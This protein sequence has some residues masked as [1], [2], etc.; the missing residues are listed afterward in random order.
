MIQVV[1]PLSGAPSYYIDTIIPPDSFPNSYLAVNPSG[2]VS[3]AVPGISI[4]PSQNAYQIIVR[5][6][7]GTMTNF[8]VFNLIRSEQNEFSPIL[9]HSAN[10]TTTIP[11][12]RPL[13][14]LVVDVNA[15]D[16]DLGQYGNITYEFVNG[17]TNNVFS[18]NSNTGEI[19]IGKLLNYDTKNE[20][21]LRIQA[22]NPVDVAALVVQ[23]VIAN[24]TV[25][26][27]AVPQFNSTLYSINVPETGTS[28][29]GVTYDRPPAGFI[30]VRCTDADTNM[31]EITYSLSGANSDVFSINSTTGQLKVLA[32]LDYDNEDSQ[33]YEFHAICSDDTTS[34]STLVQIAVQPVNEYSPVVNLRK[35]G[36]TGNQLLIIQLFETDLPINQVVVSAT[37][38][39]S[40]VILSASDRDLG[41]D[42]QLSFELQPPI[43]ENGVPLLSINENTGEVI[44]INELD[45]DSE[46]FFITYSF[47]VGARDQPG[48]YSPSK[49]QIL[50]LIQEAA[51]ELPE[52]SLPTYLVFKSEALPINA[53]VVIANC[54]DHDNTKGEFSH[55]DFDNETDTIDNLFQLDNQ[56]GQIT[57]IGSLDYE[58]FQT[59]SFELICY[60]TV[61]YFDTAEVIV[62]VLPV[63]DKIPYFSNSTYTFEVSRTTPAN[64]FYIGAVMAFDDDIGYGANLTYSMESSFFLI[65]PGNGR[66][67]LQ[68][69]I[70]NAAGDILEFNVTVTDDDE[71]HSATALVIFILTAGNYEIPQ[72]TTNNPI[73][74]ISELT[75]ANT[76][77]L[78]LHCNDSEAG[79]NGRISYEIYGGNVGSVFTIDKNSGV[80]SIVTPIIL[81]QNTSSAN[82]LLNVR[83]SDHG[84]PRHSD[85]TVARIIVVYADTISPDISN[86]TI[87]A[88]VDEDA[89]LSDHV[90]TIT[91]VDYDT[92]QLSFFFKSESVPGA[93]LI[94]TQGGKTGEVIVNSILNRETISFYEMIVVAQEV[95]NN[96]VPKNDSADLF[97]Y[98]RDVNDN[99]PVCNVQAL[100]L[101]IPENINV[102]DVIYT[103]NCN[104]SDVGLNANLTYSL[105]NNYGIIGINSQGDIFLTNH[106][107]MTNSSTLNLV[108][109]V[110]DQ[111]F[112]P[113]SISLTIIV[114]IQTMNNFPPTFTN[115]PTSL[116]I[117]EATA[118]FQLPIF[119][120]QAE[121]ADRGQYGI[122]RYSLVGQDTLPF[123]LVPNTG[124]LY[125]QEK[126][127]HH[128]QN[129]YTLNIS[130]S[131]S[132][133]TV[134]STLIINVLDANEYTPT[135]PSTLFTRSI[136]ENIVPSG[137]EPISLGCSDDDKGS[138]GDITY[139]ILSG[140]TNNDFT[141]SST[142]LIQANNKLNY[143]TTDTY[144]LKI[145][146][147]DLGNPAR[148]IIVTV[149][150]TVSP[151]NE[152]TPQ[153]HN[154]PYTESIYED[155]DIGY[156]VF[157][158]NATDMDSG[159]D[160]SLEY[161]LEPDQTAFGVTSQGDV[162]VTGILDRE[163]TSNYS[164]TV[165]VSDMGT[166][167][168]S[169]FASVYIDILD[170]DD[171][172]PEFTKSLYITTVSAD[173]AKL[174]SIVATTKCIDLDVGSNA[175]ISYS[176][177]PSTD[178]SYFSISD[179]GVITI[180]NTLPIS[181]VYSFGVQCSGVLNPNL[182]DTAHVSITI[183]IQSNITFENAT[184][185]YTL[186]EDIVPIY[187]FLTI[188]ATTVT[189]TLLTYSLINSPSIFQINGSSGDLRLVGYLDFETNS[190]YI[191]IVEA[192]DSGTP[193]NTAQVA[194]NILV[195]NINDGV[196]NF[197][198]ATS[199]IVIIEA[200]QYDLPVG[201]YVCTDSDAGTF[202][203]IT[204]SIISGN[205][206]LSF[207]INED[208]GQL[209]LKKKLDYEQTQSLNLQVQCADGGLPAQTDSVIVSVI[210]QPVNEHAPQFSSAVISLTIDE[211]L[212]IP[213]LITS[214][215]DL[216]ATDADLSPHNQIWYSIISGNDN[217]VF[218]ISSTNG[219][220]TLIKNLNFE[221]ISSYILT[222][223]ADDSGGVDNPSYTVLNSTVQVDITVTDANDNSPM[224]D[225]NIYVGSIA[226]NA[227][228]GD[229]VDLIALNCTDRDSGSN[230]QTVLSITQG[231]DGYAFI[232]LSNGKFSV[233]NTLDFESLS[234][235]YLT[236]RCSD[237]G[238]TPNFDEVS[239]IINI[240][241]VSEFGPEFEFPY[242]QFSVN[243]T[244]I[245][246]MIVGRVVAIDQDTGSAGQITYSIN[247]TTEIPFVIDSNTG[248]IRVSSSLDYEAGT[249]TYNINVIAYDFVNQ[250][251]E[252]V[253]AITLLNVDEHVPTLTASNYFGRIRESSS[254]G[255]LVLF[256][257]PISCSDADDV[258]DDL[259]TTFS[260]LSSSDAPL[261]DDFPFNLHQTTGVMT[262][263]SI[264]DLETE[265]RY[266]FK[267]VCTDSAGNTATAVITI[268]L[269]P[270][271]DFAP[272]FEGTPYNK[273]ITEGLSENTEIFT[274][275]ATDDDLSSYNSITYGI[276]SGNEEGRFS[277]DPLS[278]TIRNIQDIDYEQETQYILNISATNVIP[279]SD[280]SGSPELSSYI[281]LVINIT[282][283]NDN[284]PVITPPAVSALIRVEDPPGTFVATMTCDDADSDNFGE[285]SMS[286]TGPNS[287]KFELLANGTIITV[288]IISFDL[289]LLVNCTDMGP[290]PL[291]TLAQITVSSS[292][293]N[294]H[295]PVFPSNLKNFY[296]YE[297]F[298]VGES[299]GCFPANDSDGTLTPDGIITYTFTLLS[300]PNHFSVSQTT[301]C[302][303]LVAALDYDDDS[304]YTYKLRAQDG[305]I[306]Q[307]YADA[308]VVISILNVEFDPP[309]FVSEVFSREMSEG[310][311][312]GAIVTQNAVCTDRDDD[313]IITYSIVGGNDDGIFAINSTTGL[314]TLA[315]SLDYESAIL[316]SIEVRCTD[317]TSLYDEVNVTITV[318]PVNEH[319]PLIISKLV[320]ANEQSSVGTPITIIDYTDLDAGMDGQVTFQIL[321][322]SYS[323][324]FVIAGHTLLFNE[325]LDREIQ[326]R[327]DISMRVTDLAPISRFSD[328]YVNV[329]LTDINDNPPV[330]GQNVYMASPI[331]ENAT[332]GDHVLTVQCNDSDIGVNAQVE[333][334]I[335]ENSLFDVHINNGKVTVK[336]DLRY[337]DQDTIALN[338]YCSDKGTPKLTTS[339][340][341]QIPIHS[342]N[343]H[344][345]V[346]I[347]EPFTVTI[348]ENSTTLVPFANVTA[349]D[350]DVGLN[351]RVQYNLLDDFDNQF[352]IDQVTGEISLLLPLD[353]ETVS[354]YLL[355][356]QA[357]DGSEDSLHMNRKTDVLNVTV[358]VTGINEHTPVCTQPI[359]TGIINRTDQG[360]VLRLNCTDSDRGIDGALSYSIFNSYYSPLFSV[361]PNGE[362]VIKSSI[363]GNSSVEVYVITVIVSDMGQPMKQ[364]EV[365]VNLIYSFIN[366]DEP[367][368]NQT[369]YTFSL[370]EATPIGEVVYTI[371]A[372][373]EDPGIQGDILYSIQGTDYFRVNPNNGELYISKE[374]DWETNSIVTFMLVATDGDPYDPLSNSASVNVTVLDEND[375][376]PHCTLP[377]YTVIIGSSL[378]IGE[379]V[380][381]IGELCYDNDGPLHSI[382]SYKVQPASTFVIDSLGRISVNS[383]LT[384]STTTALTVTVNDNG[385]PQLS[386]TVTVTIQV[387]FDNIASPIFSLSQ[388]S[389]NISEDANLLTVIG[390]VQATD[391]D[392][393]T[394]DLTYS[395]TSVDLA[396]VFY[397]DPTFGDIVLISPLNYENRVQYV[398]TIKVDDAGGYNG[399]NILSDTVSVTISVLNV[400]DHSPVLNNGGL[401]GASVN[402]TTAI[403]TTIITVKC[404]DDDAVPFGNPTITQNGF[405][406]SFPFNLLSSGGNGSITVAEDLTILNGS[407]TYVVNFTCEDQGGQ[408]TIGQVYLFVPDLGAPIFNATS[409]EWQ[410]REDAE[411]GEMFTSIQA[412]SQDGTAISYSITDGNS[413]G[414]F[415]I[416]PDTGVISLA[417][418]LDY[419]TQ[420]S[421]GLIL[422]ATDGHNRVSSVLL[423]VN[424]LDV[425]DHS[426]LVSPSAFMEVE[427]F[428]PP[429]YPVG[430][431]HCTDEDS[432]NTTFN[433]EFT[434]SIDTFR[435]DSNGIIYVNET[436]DTTPVYVLPVICYDVTVPDI[437]STGIVTI[438]VIFVNLA[439]PQFD[440]NSYEVSIPES[441]ETQSS[442]A[443][444]HA[445]DSDIGSLG[446]VTYS[447]TAGNPNKFYIDSQSGV[448][449]L[450]TSLDREDS[451]IYTLTVKAV[452][453]GVGLNNTV[454]KTATTTVT[455]HILDVNDNFP[456]L[457]Q[458]SYVKT[459][460]TN[461]TYLSSVLQV[462]CSDPDLAENGTFT[463][464]IE[465][466]HNSFIINSNGTILLSSIQSSQMVHNFFVVCEDMGSIPLSSSSLVTVVVSKASFASPV[467]DENAYIVS[468]P[469]NQ[470][471][472]EPFLT[473]SA[474]TSDN[475][476]VVYLI[477]AG[478]DGNK[479]YINAESG[480]LTVVDTLSYNQKNLYTLTIRASTTGFVQYSSLV[481][482]NIT[483]TDINDHIPY[484][485]P[486][487]FYTT[488]VSE[489]E[490]ILTP[491]VQVNCS[492]LD[493]TDSLIYS[494]ID[495]TPESGLNT[496]NITTEGLIVIQ[497]P[498][499]YE[500][501]TLFSLTVQCSDGGPT[502]AEAT[503]RVNV[504]PV[505]EFSPLF[506]LPK[507]IFNA[508][509]NE[510]LG[511]VLGNVTA[512]DDDAG[513]H[514]ELIYL[515]QDPGNLSAVFIEPASGAVLVSNI[516]DYETKNFYNLSVIARDYGGR[517]SYV[518]VEITVL[519]VQDVPPVLTPSASVYNGR[520]LTTSPQGLFIKSYICVDEDGGD[521]TISIISGNDM[522]YFVLN[523]FNHVVWDGIS[524]SLNSDIVVSLTLECVDESNAK[525]TA[526]LAI[527]IGRPDT[528][529]PVFTMSTYSSTIKENATTGTPVLSVLAS[530]NGNNTI[531]YSLFNLPIGFPF[532]I[533][534]ATGE[535][536]VNGTLDFEDTQLYSFP[537]QARDINDSTIALATV[538]I[539]VIDIN[540]NY[541]LL[542]PPSLSV[543]LPENSV[544][545]IPYAK[546]TCTDQDDN[547]NSAI[548][549]S[550]ESGDSTM[551]FSISETTG[552]VYLQTSLN[553]ESV[554]SYNITV[555]CTD[556]G[557][558]QLSDSSTLLVQVS[559]INEHYPQFTMESYSFATSEKAALSSVVGSVNATD[560]DHGSNGNFYFA[561]YGGS[562]S[563]YFLVDFATGNISVKNKLNASQA[564]RLTLIVAAIDYGPPTPLISTV[565]V[566]I[567]IEDVNEN[568]YFD[569]LAYVVS[570]EANSIGDTLTTITCYDYDLGLN[571]QVSL[572]VVTNPLTGNVSLTGGSTIGNGSISK[573]LIQNTSLTTGSYEIIVQCQDYGIPFLATNVSVTIIVQAANTPPVFNKQVYGLSVNENV[574]TGTALL[575]ISATDAETGVTY[576][577]TGGT[578]LGTFSIHPNT[579]EL[580]LLASLDYESTFS[581]LLT[582]SAIDG[583]VLNPQT[584]TAKIS[585]VV[586]N[587]NDRNPTLS[588]SAF[589]TTLLE[590]F[591][592]NENIH[593][594]TCTDVDGGTTD[595]TISPSP[596]FVIDNNGQVVFN[597]TADYEMNTVVTG[598]IVC[599]DSVIAAGDSIRSS[600]ATLS[601]SITPV[602]FFPP[603][604]TSPS[605]FNVSEGT[606]TAQVIATVSAYDPDVR[607]TVT[608]STES[609][610]DMFT[611]NSANGQL[612]LLST[613][614]RETTDAYELTITASDNDNVQ[615]VSP[616]T[617]TVSIIINVTDIN[618]RSPT[619]DSTLETITIYANTY[620]QSVSLFN[621]SCRDLDIGLNGELV[622]T[623]DESS[624]P[625]EAFFYLDEKTG[626]FSFNGTITKSSSGSVIGI[627]VSDLGT[628]PV[629]T[630]AQIQL[631]L[632]VITGT[633]PRFEPNNF[634]VTI[635][636]SSPSLFLVLN[637]SVL[638][639]SL[640]FAED[641]E[642]SFKFI[643]N[644]TQFLIDSGTGNVFVLPT[645]M[646]DYDEGQQ[647]YSLGITATVGTEETEASLDIY[648]SDY[649][650][651]APQFT[652]QLYNGTV[653][654]NLDPGQSVLTVFATDIDS[655]SNA[656]VMYSILL[657]GSSFQINPVSGLI[658]SNTQFD[659]ET[660]S[661]YTF[662]V[663]ARDMGN[664]AMSSSV[665]VSIEIGDENDN[666]PE[667][668]QE[669]YSFFISDISKAG[670]VLHT[671][672]AIDPD[673]TGS[674]SYS[675]V[676]QNTF[677]K[678]FLAINP[679][680]GALYLKKDVPPN[681]EL[682]YSFK[683]TANDEIAT[684]ET[685]VVIQIATLRNKS[686]SMEENVANQSF[687]VFQFLQLS[688][689]LTSNTVYTIIDGDEFGH[690]AVMNNGLLINVIPLDRENISFYQLEISA[691]DN[692][693]NTNSILF[694]DIDV[695]DQNDNNPIFNSSLYWFNITEKHYSEN[696]IIGYVFA[697]DADKKNTENSRITYSL[698]NYHSALQVTLN[699]VTGAVSVS[700]T[701]DR[702]TEEITVLDIQ[703]QDH[704][705]PSP[706]YDYTVCRIYIYDVND[707][708]PRFS[709]TNVASFIVYFIYNVPLG[710]Y[711]EYIV[712]LRPFGTP[713]ILQAFE[714]FDEDSSDTVLAS[715][716]GAVNVTL[717]NSTSPAY[718]ISTGDITYNLNNTEFEIILSDGDKAH[719]VKKS[720]LVMILEPQP[721]V[722][723]V[724]STIFPSSTYITLSESMTATPTDTG[725]TFID[726][727]LGIAII[728]VGSVMFFAF[729]FFIFC[730]VCFCY[731]NYQRKKDTARRLV[732]G[733]ILMYFDVLFKASYKCFQTCRSRN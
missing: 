564:E 364:T 403:G 618:D 381:N 132:G 284:N 589:S 610:T 536:T 354:V 295:T 9:T 430:T 504:G 605:S 733:Y 191:L 614:D 205:T 181:S 10:L 198:S 585:I 625:N 704:G 633:E 505:N 280:S 374:L 233:N 576:A 257:S 172:P 599:T 577:L 21:Q 19:T 529:A 616:M 641:A 8:T 346:F 109:T 547:I 283:I 608:Y 508:T 387:T 213:T 463:Y 211:S 14:S 349:T 690:F 542:L 723:S 642:I 200:L 682:V 538:E 705:E 245:P 533:D 497:Q 694:I 581:Y 310:T 421:Y 437:I 358:Q 397:I 523:E 480:D 271:N 146:V 488:T 86:D 175:A 477:T 97:I 291:Y 639:N 638:I 180:N 162:L 230:G 123:L 18:I 237:Q 84:I 619:C 329:T 98:L 226:E 438:E 77:V 314:I 47:R 654:E 44:V 104:D 659:R 468:I 530:G 13:H 484:F 16:S 262:S 225:Q 190:S 396:S 526:S 500:T 675:L 481:T 493:P 238:S 630:P 600:T 431:I 696:T 586:V 427:Q 258:A 561:D 411:S 254:P 108:I 512:T 221:T 570:T 601:I 632:V 242:Y 539:T 313:D 492:D 260:L 710:S 653:M 516:L 721:S 48:T 729:V 664:P 432:S 479:F 506:L 667:F 399:T 183:E 563:P 562:G 715:L 224:F 58:T 12:N 23:Y 319:T 147:S 555:V 59:I 193:P 611:L 624:L 83:C 402:K 359:Y 42:G 658:T 370:S 663:E 447:I 89:L 103:L 545:G 449:N 607:G 192:T 5:C 342:I 464:S 691:V 669:L 323:S 330:P 106:L 74:S 686:I 718:L 201:S 351:G 270:Y 343:Q 681:Y 703:A 719:Q 670:E 711:P 627:S 277:I 145:Q 489:S 232:I 645:A 461:H 321:D 119:T 382:L 700:G 286:L 134:Y 324:L 296:V 189:G 2:N 143:E 661:S 643:A 112:T 158:V 24:V 544:T 612:I 573:S 184:Y 495:S 708:N 689:N 640:L 75:P 546:F 657:G 554:K 94:S 118:V 316:H 442:V 231:N 171:S 223:Q 455:V 7:V 116:N 348:A 383:A 591:Y 212:S 117:S 81:P 195:E 575:N 45:A 338:I 412:Q 404:T 161:S 375:N 454:R 446:E 173:M 628:N 102:G 452:D 389:F 678:T 105:Q 347:Q 355:M 218:A 121:D 276:A 151:V 235:Y 285:V 128:V 433:F 672:S 441:T 579:G 513:S 550:I 156:T 273:T 55:I 125:L 662:S 337:R 623:L 665:I 393:P 263:L 487:P 406:S 135:C 499:D 166:V 475:Q 56:T 178:S 569:Q 470:A 87:I 252:T 315:T 40:L 656:K 167:E 679:F 410:L 80:I 717:E 70:E 308:T 78:T 490:G 34:D 692:T 731:Q 674:I 177:I 469:E 498:L 380:F 182:T 606:E 6:T 229:F 491:V 300:G 299:I 332:V 713:D 155:T 272:A 590:G 677:L 602:N 67:Y 450:L 594:F 596:P 720:V 362:I 706:R 673:I 243:E 572:N 553:Y 152:F 170:V 53:T 137:I 311:V 63:N 209:R 244:A 712:A 46:G 294:D 440:F 615:G 603:V 340:P 395:L 90:V 131:D 52:F 726:T 259:S 409:Y 62:G 38:N 520:V 514:G 153:I 27:T 724:S 101:Q 274:V 451:D 57:L 543:T 32:N 305:G 556:G 302:I 115:L 248:N 426:P 384:P 107:N 154:G 325:V 422:K 1:C 541:P 4:P 11:E 317:S 206:D 398:L 582:V 693:S 20:Y 604:F 417:G 595:M 29:S 716:S 646:L 61:G 634:N 356:V 60:D 685:D 176:L 194:V 287:E 571:A 174:G 265:D 3:L 415:Y 335:E 714:F 275:T 41:A 522:S 187:T 133:F 320:S 99:S 588:P 88:F 476:T 655:S 37:D 666:P 621:A 85:T 695:A 697:T 100:S 372:N 139:Q 557:S 478:N 567:D 197:I 91:A 219:H 278:G 617:T 392:S 165:L 365:E 587:V 150:I 26:I 247:N 344:A 251:D 462:Q 69:S 465:P 281:D 400:N 597:G 163:K 496:F 114:N 216:Q 391:A 368:F 684:A 249:I 371:L 565:A 424:V 68:Q 199:N 39:S 350:E 357:I 651:N 578:G 64:L 367:E 227:E 159:D 707:N 113:R 394:S 378:G 138:N 73:V 467:F 637:G 164:F 127:D 301:G 436:L 185:T 515:L 699:S 443:T 466:P 635:S 297:N 28:Q 521:T 196:P 511:V 456:R 483:I 339:F 144:N 35:P 96:G 293:T 471:Q 531:E 501:T 457:D 535:I 517:E 92:E 236:V 111:G 592:V 33:F 307:R 548:T 418:T 609:H 552:Y 256:L 353:Y 453:G 676:S 322:S 328:G 215:N 385:S 298:T 54:T 534:S 239:V 168:R 292:S 636:E 532:Q 416:N 179:T 72:F 429:N 644:S 93:F 373:D 76:E 331:N 141:V 730:L 352:Y 688:S 214:N 202:G 79:D 445:S 30:T 524:V 334:T 568:P 379:T 204:Y 629:S 222:V 631:I 622:Y 279:L 727:P 186:P 574:A 234:A 648:L 241:D 472:L 169:A 253:V 327:Y 702:E 120:V 405:D 369:L 732:F 460:F 649:N 25:Y 36:E 580:S 701:V 110:S 428:R 474:S 435:I 698:L 388:Y 413:N 240:N 390:Q 65:S 50:L 43:E 448:I 318:T 228:P 82:F 419:E 264:L 31:D 671:F 130:A 408:R 660:I 124:D 709:T 203:E 269:D 157:H 17:N 680:T 142:G 326:S 583:D 217:Q 282:D 494:I 377:F 559:G 126:L 414:E 220:L 333:Y 584:S 551:S 537:V 502:P 255:T 290:P 210:V 509:E 122:V 423:L 486:I 725:V 458:P 304:S 136:L 246:G 148:S 683:V 652:K 376:T 407:L 434:S 650:D 267:V 336:S 140:N 525:D 66:I 528:T 306:P 420:M 598:T 95:I 250:T 540:D 71:L 49:Q 15:T 482:V 558:P 620:N 129:L 507:Y 566:D 22:F 386:T 459:I 444:V 626:E 687:D 289:I 722:T 309:E 549:Y 366:S 473:V 312:V 345:P 647:K 503:V 485:T 149:R 363:E 266:F 188:N 728:I 160:G 360:V 593:Q 518:P 341:I 207:S 425:D 439:T 51:D 361:T 527:I 519:N 208:G 401:Y 613:L 268:N 510:E 261:D 668:L 560:A 288:Q 303:V